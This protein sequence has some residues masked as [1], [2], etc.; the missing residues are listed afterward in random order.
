MNRG[1]RGKSVQV[2][3]VED[4]E[5]DA[6]ATVRQLER[7]GFQ[8][9]FQR[10]QSA[11]AFSDALAEGRWELV[12]CDHTLPKF[13][14]T[15]ALRIFRKSAL[16]IPFI[17]V[18]GTLGEE[19]AVSSMRE[20]AS[21][22]VL[23]G[24]LTR[25]APA[26]ERELSE[27]RIRHQRRLAEESLRDNASHLR[28]VLDHASEGILTLDQEGHI[29]SINREGERLLGQGPGL[30]GWDFR[31]FLEEGQDI[32]RN[33]T[34]ELSLRRPELGPLQV[35]AQVSAIRL[36]GERRVLVLLRDISA[37]HQLEQRLLLM[38]RWVSLGILASGVAHEIN[39]PLSFLISNL[40]FSL[41]ELKHL[42][43]PLP[44]AVKDALEEISAALTEARQGAERIEKIISEMRSFSWEDVTEQGPVSVQ[45]V[46]ESAVNL[47]R[48]LMQPRARL[49]REFQELP[50]ILSN[51]A[52]LG[53]VFL[54]LLR[55]AAQR[56]PEKG[57]EQHVIT[58]RTQRESATHVRIEVSD[59]GPTLNAEQ[60]KHVF[61]P[62]CA[63]A[64]SSGLGL[65]IAS[66]LLKTLGGELEVRGE[67]GRGITLRI[68]LP[69]SGTL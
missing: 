40:G 22:Y 21:D 45:D 37:R 52:G 35:E 29:R 59:T 64:A 20:G 68:L 3:L 28:A 36:E 4:S 17:M 67:Q 63:E 47:S 42:P 5:R 54:N 56:L 7:A 15:E 2:L 25:L 57:A 62:F 11:D 34:F 32:F 61:A 49:V 46:L 19:A 10:V 27:A 23:K 13:N 53:Q 48:S 38:G 1:E 39:N 66:G 50:L 33:G 44:D 69:V 41:K 12:L 16:D 8:V 43:A 9:Q 31:L 26:V 30:L 65:S 24:N 14:G 55:Y 6:Q 58:L 60:L 51:T 18:S